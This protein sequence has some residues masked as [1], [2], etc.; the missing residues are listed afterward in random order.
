MSIPGKRKTVQKL[1]QKLLRILR[2]FQYKIV[3]V[4]N[5]KMKLPRHDKTICTAKNA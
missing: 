2:M 3:T 1:S 5:V 4:I